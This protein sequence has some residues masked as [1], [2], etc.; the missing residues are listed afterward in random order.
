LPFSGQKCKQCSAEHNKILA[1]TI[2]TCKCTTY[3]KTPI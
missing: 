2:I 3:S 1:D